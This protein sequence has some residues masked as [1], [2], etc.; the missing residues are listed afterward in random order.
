MCEP[1]TIVAAVT[2]VVGAISTIQQG[3]AQA[4]SA[5]YNAA[6][7]D[8]NAVIARQQAAEEARRIRDAGARALGQQRTAFAAAG[9]T[10]EGTPLEVLGDTA[11]SVELDALT[12]RYSGEVEATDYMARANLLRSQAR[13]AERSAMFGAGTS[14]LTSAGRIGHG[15]YKSLSTPASKPSV[16][17]YGATGSGR[18]IVGNTGVAG[19]GT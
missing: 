10:A 9:V 12:A 19:G 2:A 17:G 13:S 5:R 7:A 11:A 3:R 14:L 6:I 15:A 4:A 1:M 8:R 18:L 16:G